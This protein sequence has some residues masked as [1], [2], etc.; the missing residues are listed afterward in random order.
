MKKRSE[1][2]RLVLVQAIVINW[3]K[4][5]RG[6]PGTVARNRVP[7][8]LA[9]PATP[10]DVPGA[11]RKQRPE[12]PRIEWARGEPVP[13]EADEQRQPDL[14]VQVLSFGGSN[15][16][17]EPI[18]QRWAALTTRLPLE[19]ILSVGSEVVPV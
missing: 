19:T 11:D 12:R 6:A 7:E 18:T 1:P 5:S 4:D 10:P 15:A 14:F 9:L 16:F 8:A 3:L 17:R 13:G 2:Q